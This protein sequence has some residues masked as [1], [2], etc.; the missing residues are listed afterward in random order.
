MDRDLLPAPASNT[1]A[2]PLRPISAKKRRRWPWWA[3]AGMLVA[4]GAGV[5]FRFSN[6]A[7]IQYL[8]APV[9]RGAVVQRITA[10]GTVNPVLSIVVGAQVSGVIQQLFCDYNA[11]VRVGQICA[12]IDP[13]P[14]DATLA[15]YTGQLE[16]DQALLRQARMNLERYQSLLPKG[17]IARQQAEDQ[18]HLVA[19]EEGLVKLDEAQV[20]N[21][22]LD[23]LY[24]NITA[25]VEGT[26]VSRNVTQ[27]QTV[28]SSFQTPTLF[29]IAADLKQM[30]VDTNVSESDVATGPSGLKVGDE[31]LFTVDAFPDRSF[32]G[33]VIQI[34]QSPQTVQNVV[35]Y[36]VVVSVDNSDRALIPGM[37]ASTQII[38]DRRQ[39]V[40]RVPNQ[41]LRYRPSTS[42]ATPSP[43]R[44]ICFFSAASW[45]TSWRRG[46]L[47]TPSPVSSCTTS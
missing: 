15:Q 42:G 20:Q 1:E 14:F 29:L 37:T 8:T 27:G 40:V 26:V 44:E 12:K 6:N 41:A 22:K 9:T 23:L 45:I 39:N 2:P 34:R 43:L 30:E 10:T 31:A 11:Q 7:Q 21:A 16:R 28:A 5:W 35:T 4:A 38:L 47:S 32:R 19:Q 36:D 17:G 46:L 18:A 24:T 13:R 3:A 33:T 25:P